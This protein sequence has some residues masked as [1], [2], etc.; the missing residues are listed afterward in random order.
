MLNPPSPSV[1]QTASPPVIQSGP[2][3]EWQELPAETQQELILILASLLLSQPE[4]GH[5]PLA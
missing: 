5:E 4:V 1:S 2:L 3:P